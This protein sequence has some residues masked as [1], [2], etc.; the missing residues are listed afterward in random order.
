MNSASKGSCVDKCTDG[1]IASQ[2]G[3]NLCE[4]CKE[5]CAKC[6]DNYFEYIKGGR[7]NCV[8]SCPTGTIEVG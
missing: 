2:N 8:E 4:I 5:N 3:S 6:L 7:L 1:Y